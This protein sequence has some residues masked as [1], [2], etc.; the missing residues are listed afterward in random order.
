MTVLTDQTVEN[1]PRITGSVEESTV[2]SDGMEYVT[3]TQWRESPSKIHPEQDFL[4][5]L[6]TLQ[7]EQ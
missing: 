1:T 4:I 5:C 3:P 2:E 6:S 7:G